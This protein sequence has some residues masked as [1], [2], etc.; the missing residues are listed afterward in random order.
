M[1]KPDYFFFSFLRILGLFFVIQ[2][3]LILW[4]FLKIKA[5]STPRTLKFWQK[6]LFWY[7]QIEKHF[8]SKNSHFFGHFLCVFIIYKFQ[9]YEFVH[10]F[11]SH[12][13]LELLEILNSSKR[14]TNLKCKEDRFSKFEYLHFLRPFLD[15]FVGFSM[16]ISAI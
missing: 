16:K 7:Q 9:N 4:V 2:K 8:F 5:I 13:T 1:T 14:L 3:K 10:D 11:L 15:F 12:E 6:K